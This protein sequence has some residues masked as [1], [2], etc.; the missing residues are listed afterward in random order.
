MMG[1]CVG[2]IY[3][4]PLKVIARTSA[5]CFSLLC[6]TSTRYRRVAEI[7]VDASSMAPFFAPLKC[8]INPLENE[9]GYLAS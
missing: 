6:R 3:H 8:G 4:A 9:I 5:S 7:M 2:N 1:D